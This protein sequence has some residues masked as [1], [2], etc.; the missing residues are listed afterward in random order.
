A[1]VCSSSLYVQTCGCAC[2]RSGLGRGV[3]HRS[4]S[5]MQGT[6]WRAEL[7]M[8][9]VARRAFPFIVVLAL[10]ETVARLQYF[11]SRLFPSLDAIAAAFVRLSASG[12]LPH[13]AADTML[14]LMAGFAVAAIAGIAI[15][16]VMGRSRLAQ[17]LALPLVSMGAPIPGIAYAPLFLL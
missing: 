6:D 7:R 9:A 16:I 13:H 17:D 8:R 3:A 15:G 1:A 2:G 10:W 4:G 12:A 14:R 5:A 11:A